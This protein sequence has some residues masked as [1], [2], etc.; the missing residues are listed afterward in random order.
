MSGPTL[1][2][3]RWRV[4]RV[5]VSV[6]NSSTS[7]QARQKDIDIIRRLRRQERITAATLDAEIDDFL[8]RF[9]TFYMS[10]SASEEAVKYA[11]RQNK[12]VSTERLSQTNN[13]AH[14]GQEI[15]NHF[16]DLKKHIKDLDEEPYPNWQ[17]GDSDVVLRQLDDPN[18]KPEDLESELKTRHKDVKRLLDQADEHYQALAK[19][20]T[21]LREKGVA[22]AEAVADDFV[23]SR[24]SDYNFANI[25]VPL[26]PV[27]LDTIDEDPAFLLAHL[28]RKAP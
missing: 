15:I 18:L 22:A 6:R 5:A 2:V 24:S 21:A 10:R 1:A 20:R 23:N 26:D 8:Q 19:A 9:D 25:N 17:P 27:D 4:P 28:R 16:D 7:Q 13:L 3:L 14:F 11:M 12:Y